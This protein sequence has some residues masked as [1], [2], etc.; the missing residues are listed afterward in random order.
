LMFYNASG[1][2]IRLYGLD[3]SGKRVARH[4]IGDDLSLSFLTEVG[5]PWVVADQS[6]RCLE[7]VLPGRRTRYHTVEAPGSGPVADHFGSRRMA[8]L[9]DSEEKLRR[10]IE[11]LA[12]GQPDYDRMTAEVAVQTRQQLS[13]NRAILA[14][15]G[16][17]HAMT[18]RGVT[19]IGSD[20]YMAHF[21]NGSAEW[22]ISLAK[23]GS[24]GR[25]GLG[26]SY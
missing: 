12:A 8:P 6:G 15:L 3:P 24:I 22:R 14:R 13:M 18:F 5:S 4:A 10:Y 1:D 21:A 16:P 2:E 25:I 17:L 19:A 23:D 11:A 20:I 9:A 26:P 7:I